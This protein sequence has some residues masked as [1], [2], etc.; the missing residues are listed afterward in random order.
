[1]DSP[2]RIMDEEKPSSREVR[3]GVARDCETS[4]TTDPVVII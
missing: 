2:A 4:L 3:V 1:M